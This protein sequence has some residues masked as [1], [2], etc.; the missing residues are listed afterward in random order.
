MWQFNSI[1]SKEPSTFNNKFI[2]SCGIS[3]GSQLT[4]VQLY[5]DEEPTDDQIMI[6]INLYINGLN[7]ANSQNQ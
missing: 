3:D 6:D 7:N 5:Y 4:A 1:L 2:V